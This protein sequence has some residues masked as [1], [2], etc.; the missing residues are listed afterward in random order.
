[1]SERGTLKLRE[2]D[3]E[4]DML[5]GLYQI[6]QHW[7]LPYP[8]GKV[9]SGHGCADKIRD[10]PTDPLRWIGVGWMVAVSGEWGKGM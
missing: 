10:V 8:E 9:V 3:I 6:N 1:M 7:P 5:A 4:G 2:G